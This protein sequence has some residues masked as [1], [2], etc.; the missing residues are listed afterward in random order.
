MVCLTVSKIVLSGRSPKS[1]RNYC[2]PS[3]AGRDSG[4]CGVEGTDSVLGHLWPPVTT[5]PKYKCP[6]KTEM[7]V[8]L[9][10]MKSRAGVMPP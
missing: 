6:G 9:T 8:P 2:T 7:S 5:T 3:C 4:K 10:G 1:A